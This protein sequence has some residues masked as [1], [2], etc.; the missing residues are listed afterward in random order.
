MVFHVHQNITAQFFY[1]TYRIHSSMQSFHFI[2]FVLST[3][4]IC[5]MKFADTSKNSFQKL[6]PSLPQVQYIFLPFLQL[7]QEN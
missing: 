5:K 4:T 7:C 1:R 2:I 6:A 3:F